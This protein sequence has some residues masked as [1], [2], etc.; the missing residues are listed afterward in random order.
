M[1][2][3][4][5]TQLSTDIVA[6]KTKM[7]PGQVLSLMSDE[8]AFGFQTLDFRIVNPSRRRWNFVLL[9]GKQARGTEA[10]MNAIW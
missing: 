3:H 5:N 8:K 1:F 9:E 7:D 6:I 2:Q 4:W 10:E